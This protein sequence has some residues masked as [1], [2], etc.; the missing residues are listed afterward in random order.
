MRLKISFL[1]LIFALTF[2]VG[3]K[4]DEVTEPAY[5]YIAPVKLSPNAFQGE[6]SFYSS[7]VHLFIDGQDQG[8]YLTGRVY[9]INV[10]GT[11]KLDILGIIRTIND[12]L[13]NVVPII[14]PFWDTYAATKNLTVGKVDTIYPDFKYNSISTFGLIENFEVGHSFT[15]DV[16]KNPATNISLSNENGPTGKYGVIN[17]DN[18][19]NVIFEVQNSVKIN[20]NKQPS[21]CFLEFDYLNEIPLNVGFTVY[22][23][24]T[25]PNGT[26]FA[27]LTLNP[28]KI[29][30]HVYLKISN[31]VITSSATDLSIRLGANLIN[32]ATE[33]AT[34]KIDNLKLIYK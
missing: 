34:I 13:G 28:K 10:L 17:L 19:T 23:N 33:K 8:L 1:M 4:V 2:L 14:Y 12:G 22:S 21:D 32:S 26:T 20:F 24:Q 7:E 18:K 25:G 27:K 15:T 29:W 11:K 30:T 16:D 5:I 6:A 9:P 3:C 31:D